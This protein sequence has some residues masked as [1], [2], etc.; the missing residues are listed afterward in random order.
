M[1]YKG[2]NLWRIVEKSGTPRSLNPAFGD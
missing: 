1:C 2:G